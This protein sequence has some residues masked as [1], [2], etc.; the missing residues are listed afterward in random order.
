MGAYLK[1]PHRRRQ[2]RESKQCRV[3]SQIGVI[4]SKQRGIGEP[5]LHRRDAPKLRF[6]LSQRYGLRVGFGEGE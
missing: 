1:I 2:P 5:V 4:T 3:H 6:E